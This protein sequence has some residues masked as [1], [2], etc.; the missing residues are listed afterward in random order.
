M[1]AARSLPQASADDGGV[2]LRRIASAVGDVSEA[3]R[4]LREAVA[5]A[6]LE[7][8]T[9]A[10]IG[11]ALGISKQSAHERFVC[12]EQVVK[13]WHAVEREL[14]AIAE[15]RGLPFDPRALLEMLSTEGVLH[16]LDVSQ[17]RAL[18][19]ARNRAVHERDLDIEEAERVTDYAIPLV[20]NLRGVAA[21]S[22]CERCGGPSLGFG[23]VPLGHPICQRCYDGDLR[24]GGSRPRRRRAAR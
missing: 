6:R 20:A 9:W 23:E 10:E 3:Q 11:D 1:T 7:G 19:D 24:R 8:R 16:P 22:L 12:L 17:A 15:N 14:S 18:L 5:D 13:A 4:L 21:G 2:T